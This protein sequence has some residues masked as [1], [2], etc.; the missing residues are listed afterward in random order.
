MA[1][2]NVTGQDESASN[3][4]AE[5]LQDQ[6]PPAPP[7]IPGKV[8]VCC[9]LPHG[10]RM[11]LIDEGQLLKPAAKRKDSVFLRG[12]NARRI[13]GVPGV[14]LVSQYSVTPV[15]EE[16]AREWLR[17]NK[18]MLFVRN[19]SV[20]IEEKVEHAQKRMKEQEP[21]VSTGLE[22]LDPRKPPK[23][24]EPDKEQ[25]GKLGVTL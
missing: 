1:K 5:E 25:L 15:D 23:D 14:P 19:G 22:P 20:F 2:A 17:R 9:K 8:N 3:Q 13:Q 6:Q 16:F 10:L 7:K 11:E 18:E 21:H 24:I 4:S 12:A